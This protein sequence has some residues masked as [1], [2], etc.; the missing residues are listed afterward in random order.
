MHKIVS[1]LFPGAQLTGVLEN[2]SNNRKL[3]FEL[4]SV[5]DG[6]VRLIIDEDSS[7][8]QRYRPEEALNGQPHTSK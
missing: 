7:I 2:T 3:N 5:K 4:I 1:V 8:R 6:I